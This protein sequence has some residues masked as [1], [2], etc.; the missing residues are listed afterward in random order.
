MRSTNKRSIQ[1][2]S[3]SQNQFDLKTKLNF[4]NLPDF[5]EIIVTSQINIKS[6]IRSVNTILTPTIDPERLPNKNNLINFNTYPK[7]IKG[8]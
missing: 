4:Y 3:I 2:R 1:A 7:T 5:K 6:R 8:G